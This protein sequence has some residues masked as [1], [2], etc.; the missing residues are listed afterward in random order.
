ML[1]PGADAEYSATFGNRRSDVGIRPYEDADWTSVAALFGRTFATRCRLLREAI[2][3]GHAYDCLQRMIGEASASAAW[4]AEKGN[5]I[6][7]FV[8]AHAR[9]AG[10][11]VITTPVLGEV[12]QGAFDG[13][14]A[15]AEGF[16]R[17]HGARE[18]K[19]E[20]I[21]R[22]Y[23]VGFGDPIHM[24]LLGHGYETHGVEGLEVV[25]ELDLTSFATTPTVEGFRRQNEAAGLVFEFLHT[26]HAG[27]LEEIAEAEWMRAGLTTRLEEDPERHPY[28]VCRNGD[29]I[30]GF[31]GG[32]HVEKR[33]GMGGWAFILLRGWTA[34]RRGE[35]FGRG[36]GA[37][38]LS[39]ANE[40]LKAQDAT[41]QIIFTG[42]EN[43][44]QRL[45]RSA[46]YRYCFFSAHDVR[47]RLRP[48]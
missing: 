43:P 9:E 13:L 14:L 18:A 42:V 8:S 32:C 24:R 23:S 30:V 25:M 27:S 22:E 21:S 19:V 26:K 45:Y 2:T 31:C 16:L 5:S 10:R 4:V 7:A 39:M 15:N 46:G 47:K 34:E 40:W 20:G 48:D 41:F 6:E 44:A 29:V 28:A 38:L 11:A 36:I 3:A 12:D 1:P 37:V 17:E 35:Y 33:Y